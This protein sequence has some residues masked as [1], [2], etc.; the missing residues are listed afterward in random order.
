MEKSDQ[1]QT[2]DDEMKEGKNYPEEEEDP[3]YTNEAKDADIKLIAALE[4]YWGLPDFTDAI[5]QIMA[6]HSHKFSNS[7]EEQ[8]I[9]WYGIFKEYTK[10]VEE[11]LQKFIEGVGISE[12]SLYEWWNRIN[13]FNTNALSWIDYLVATSDYS[14]FSDMMVEYREANE[15]TPNNQQD[16]FLNSI[17]NM[18]MEPPKKT[19]KE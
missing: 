14:E 5:Q 11:L 13:E 3:E 2:H 4:E 6:E 1:P 17:L 9:E 7:E 19:K 15:W 16:D 10:T 8:N 12:E 18:K